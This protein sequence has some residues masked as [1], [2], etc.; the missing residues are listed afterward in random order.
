[1]IGVSLPFNWFADK[2]IDKNRELLDI[3]QQKGVD[4]IELRTVTPENDS[5]EVMNAAETVLQK[6]FNLTVH[7]TVRSLES[8]VSDIF[9][10]LSELLSNW[11]SVQQSVTVTIHPI[12]GDNVGML[13]ELCGYAEK[14]G[15][16]V[17]FALENNRLMPDM[18]EG[19]SA[20]L[21][22]DV[23]KQVNRKN[24]GICFDMGH[25]TYYRMKNSP[26]EKLLVPPKEFFEH[27]VHTHIHGMNGL[28]THFP[29]GKY[30]LPMDEYFPML[31]HNYFGVYNIELDFPRFCGETEPEDALFMSVEA[32]IS[33]MR[34]C[35][36]LY[37]SIR[38]DFD[39]GFMK[40]TDVISKKEGTYVSLLNS[41]SYL[42]SVDGFSFGMDIA[43]RNA[44]FLAKTPEMVAELL[45][46]LKLIIIT[47][48]HGDHFEEE[49][50]RALSK[51]DTV[52][53]I[54]DFLYD[55]AIGYGLDKNKIIIAE[56]N[57][58]LKIGPLSVSTF[59][60]SHFRPENKKGV[61]EYGYYISASGSPSMIFPGDI[62]DYSF[63]KPQKLPMADYCFCHVWFG[64]DNRNTLLCAENAA[65][66]AE[67]MLQ[68][69]QKNI[70]LAHLYEN[71]RDDEGMWRL[72][73]AEM[74]K[75]EIVARSE[76]INVEVLVHGRCFE[77]L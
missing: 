63:A 74:L 29:L 64:D 21:V 5:Q 71:G 38:H 24:V 51:N 68:L 7:G 3:L 2:N 1:M 25:Y 15:Y 75:K 32:L 22:L 26:T 34:H 44:Y 37:R 23:V 55:E 9:D 47:H 50:V 39:M 52:W 58:N 65:K 10:P 19:D 62:R 70:F 8:A 56:P 17:I 40:A 67:C 41:S 43:F 20:A 35:A 57:K 66:E 33:K 16:P 13:L 60:S 72:E 30:D 11:C 28:K 77:L 73:H 46:E 69:T 14:N 31:A 27:V 36:L 4:S 76:D 18:S 61:E 48:G 42:F 49:T 12:Q 54:P 53:L 59:E 45:N 6:G